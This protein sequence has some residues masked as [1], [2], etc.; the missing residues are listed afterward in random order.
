MKGIDNDLKLYTKI[1]LKNMPEIFGNLI[2]HAKNK[3]YK[4]ELATGTYCSDNFDEDGDMILYREGFVLYD[5][6][7]K[8]DIYGKIY[9]H[10]MIDPDEQF[11]YLQELKAEVE[12]K[13][14]S[15]YFT[16]P[17]LLAAAYQGTEQ[18]LLEFAAEMERRTGIPYISDPNDYLMPE[19]Y[20][21]DTIYHCS[22]QGQQVRSERFLEDLRAYGIVE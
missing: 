5:Y 1:P 7:E 21:Y 6:E 11:E 10:S 17:V 2:S 4:T 22:S 9:G 3:A 15:I 19:A 16:A 13:G 12:A 8:T 20:M 14:A 18:Q